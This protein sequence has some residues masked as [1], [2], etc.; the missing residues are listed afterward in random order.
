MNLHRTQDLHAACIGSGAARSVADPGQATFLSIGQSS[1]SVKQNGLLHCCLV[2]LFFQRTRVT[3][4]N[5][6]T[7]VGS[8]D[9]HPVSCAAAHTVA[10]HHGHFAILRWVA[11]R[12]AAALGPTSTKPVQYT[13]NM[14]RHQQLCPAPSNRKVASGV[15]TRSYAPFSSPS[16]F[17]T[18]SR[19]EDVRIVAS[20]P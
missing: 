15:Q 18:N 4:I 11:I 7:S 16:R 8:T 14:R 6:G 20:C 5:V 12:V 13:C 19:V 10:R 3:A 2:I 1:Q 17:Q 9:E